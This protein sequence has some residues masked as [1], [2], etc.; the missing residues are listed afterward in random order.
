MST[1]TTIPTPLLTTR[2]A[3]AYLHVSRNT[4]CAWMRDKKMPGFKMPDQSYR[5][6]LS[7][8]DAWLRQRSV[9]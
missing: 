5:F 9:L 6:R 4:L 7:D 2:E 8:L 3:M 1:T